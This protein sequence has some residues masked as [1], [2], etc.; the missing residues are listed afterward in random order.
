MVTEA[1]IRR[2]AMALPGALEQPSY[3]GRPSWRT[4]PRMFAWIRPDPEAL[5]V[6][7]ESIETKEAMIAL[8]PRRYFTTPHYDGHAIVLVRLGAIDRSKAAE[9]IEASYRVR[10][11]RSLTRG[12]TSKKVATTARRRGRT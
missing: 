6:W 10:A 8:D 5:V 3:E 4:K 11:P 1:D 12:T 7:V 2:I 9:L